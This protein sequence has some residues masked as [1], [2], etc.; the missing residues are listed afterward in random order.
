MASSF[1]FLTRCNLPVWEPPQ[2]SILMIDDDD[3]DD[4]DDDGD[5]VDGN[6]DD[7][8][9]GDGGNNNDD[10]YDHGDRNLPV[11]EP[12]QLSILMMM[13]RKQ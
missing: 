3:N 4:D 12:P 2:L 1:K 9:N 10:K 7:E 5:V 6:V 13:M 11:W 8:E